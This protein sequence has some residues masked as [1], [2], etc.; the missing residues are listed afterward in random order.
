M[1]RT[2]FPILVRAL[3]ATVLIATGLWNLNFVIYHVWA[4]DSFLSGSQE[5]SDWHQKWA[6]ILF[7][8]SLIVFIGAGAIIW[9]LFFP[10]S[11]PPEAS[12]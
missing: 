2:L 10:R 9:R 3:S 11:A 5:V 1:K 6:L 4:S 12:Q 7:G 8:I